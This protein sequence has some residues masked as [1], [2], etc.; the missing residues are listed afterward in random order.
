MEA[1]PQIK[2]VVG[3]SVGGMTALELKNKLS[4]FN[5]EC[6]WNTVL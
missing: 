2:K 6:L 1:N 5:G 4:G 3:F